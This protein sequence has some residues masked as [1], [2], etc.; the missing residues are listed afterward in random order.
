MGWTATIH[1]L[2]SSRVLSTTFEHCSTFGLSGQVGA[3]K[4]PILCSSQSPAITQLLP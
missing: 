4:E 2:S 3:T 1:D